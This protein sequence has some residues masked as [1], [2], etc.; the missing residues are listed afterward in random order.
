MVSLNTLTAAGA[1][2]TGIGLLGQY[3]PLYYISIMLLRVIGCHVYRI[4]RDK[5]RVKGITKLLEKETISSALVWEFGKVRP[6][7]YFMGRECFGYYSDGGMD[8]ETEII[9]TTT[10]AK[11]Q[12]LMD[13]TV[14]ECN[15]LSFDHIPPSK[16]PPVNPKN[17]LIWSR[18][19]SYTNIYYRSTQV[20][21]SSIEPIGEQVAIV[22][23]IVQKYKER[24]RMVAFVYG[25]TGAGKSTLGLFIAK[26][27]G[28][29]YCHT[30]NPSEPG[31]TFENL[32]RD[33]ETMDEDERKPI[34]I[35]IEEANE[36]I[37]AAHTNQVTLHKNV[38]TQV[39][40]KGTFNTFL[41]N[42]MFHTKVVLILTSNESKE[43]IDALCPSY[44]RVGRIYEYYSMLKPLE[45]M[46]SL[47]N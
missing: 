25:I 6:G 44:L 1:M 14:V 31:D 26:Q 28:G 5:D 46:D 29:I 41:D 19:G 17:V 12:K 47:K 42:M 9:I 2:M 37:R 36:M 39:K 18:A 40:S 24:Q 35:V 7:G 27:L 33:T 13:E 34:I 21:M 22:D 20:D 11:F 30:F 10:P 16:R 8:S 45:V 43:Q 23:D 15:S 4:R 3:I 32:L 38:T